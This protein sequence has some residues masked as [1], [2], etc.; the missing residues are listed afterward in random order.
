MMVKPLW[1]MIHN[2]MGKA[3]DDPTVLTG[4]IMEQDYAIQYARENNKTLLIWTHFYRMLLCYMLGDFE[5]AEVHSS[6]C[7]VAESN[8]FGTSDRVLFV[9]YD[10][11]VALSQ[12]KSRAR[13]KIAK[14]SIKTF[15]NWAKHSPEN[16]LGK[17]YL[18][19]A[20]LAAKTGEVDRA[21]SKYTSAISLSREG[22]YEMQHA[23][24]NERA[25][26]FFLDLGEDGLARPYLN[27]ALNVY[28]KWGGIMKVDHLKQ[29]LEPTT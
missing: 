8:P 23:L 20:E 3:Y 27:D 29:E 9:F 17:L 25:G 1:Q 4:D 19:E 5:S 2:F 28:S 10:G 18:L 13:L 14:N 11:L 22:G 26:K 6:V 7:R 21:H 12:K 15:K 16:F 24:A